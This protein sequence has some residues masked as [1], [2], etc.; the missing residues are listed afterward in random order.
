[1][2]QYFVVSNDGKEFG[3]VD[4]P[5]L[6]EWVRQ[7]RVLRTTL[8]RKG[9]AEPV[10]A[11]TLPELAVAFAPAPP[12]AFST[13]FT[14]APLPTEFRSWQFIGQA[15]EL[16]KPHWLPLA[17][18]FLIVAAMGATGAYV[19]PVPLH[20][21]SFLFFI[22]GGAIYVGIS[23]AILGLIAGRPPTVGMMF[24]GFDRFGQAFLAML[25]TSVLTGIG[26]I[27]CVVP[28]II[29]AI[30][31]M[32]VYLVMAETNLDFWPAMQ[33][34]AKLAEGYW[35]ELFCLLLACFVV[36][37]LGL[38]ACLVGVFVASPVVATAVA[39]AY[40]FLQTRKAATTA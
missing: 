13:S 6:L 22:I 4:L 33:A 28:G 32:F 21:G 34:S 5:G 36:T 8:V 17:L 2:D 24:G 3:P 10:A 18:M 27:F 38:L 40:R 7:S 20:A 19:L 35:W 26:M 9:A 16:V 23:R 11:E 12:T 29:L 25:V 31:W 30:M 15:W 37:L 1:M 14:S 39:L